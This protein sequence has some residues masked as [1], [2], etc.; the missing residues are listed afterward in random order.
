MHFLFYKEHDLEEDLEK[1]MIETNPISRRMTGIFLLML[2]YTRDSTY[3][4]VYQSVP[5]QPFNIA[6]CT[7][8]AS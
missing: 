4:M 8:A 2:W 3:V 1:E 6:E 5:C 7:A